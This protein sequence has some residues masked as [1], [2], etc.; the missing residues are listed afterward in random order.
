ML[1]PPCGSLGYA[2]RRLPA[3]LTTPKAGTFPEALVNGVSADMSNGT[4]LSDRTGWLSDIQEYTDVVGQAA[5][6]TGSQERLHPGFSSLRG[7]PKLAGYICPHA[8][9]QYAET[10]STVGVMHQRYTTPR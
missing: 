2:F 4:V 10:T 7:R 1:G 9:I 5:Q 8:T 6:T 3:C